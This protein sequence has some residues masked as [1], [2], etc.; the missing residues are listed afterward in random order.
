MIHRH[1]NRVSVGSSLMSGPTRQSVLHCRNE[2]RPSG[3]RVRVACGVRWSA[4]VI[5]GLA[6]DEV[7]SGANCG[8]QPRRDFY[9]FLFIFFC[10]L[11]SFSKIQI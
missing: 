5:D 6:G 1:V 4:H 11:L 10:F 3:V 7:G 2:G 9:L 8:F